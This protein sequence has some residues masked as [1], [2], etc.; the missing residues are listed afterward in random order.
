ME[1]ES[2]ADTDSHFIVL[3]SGVRGPSNDCWNNVGMA[4]RDVS[5]CSGF[6]SVDRSSVFHFPKSLSPISEE[7]VMSFGEAEGEGNLILQ[8]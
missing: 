7:G 8:S 5:D 6:A 4:D 2:D 3:S 1:Y